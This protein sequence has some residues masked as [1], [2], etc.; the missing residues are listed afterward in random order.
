ML[1]EVEV[2]V[3][4]VPDSYRLYLRNPLQPVMNG[5]PITT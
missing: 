3:C 4:T 1:R 5:D 2:V